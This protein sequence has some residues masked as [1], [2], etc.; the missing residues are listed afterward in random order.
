MG[1]SSRRGVAVVALV[2]ALSSCSSTA[3]ST[4]STVPPPAESVQLG[5]TDGP[6]A[7]FGAPASVGD[8]Q[9]TASNPVVGSDDTGPWLT[10]TV[11]AENQSPADTAA[12]QFQLRCSGSTAGGAWLPTSTF[13]QDQSVPAGAA[14]EGTLSLLLPGDEHLGVARPLCATPATVV[15]THLTFDNNGA[16]APVEKR[17]TWAVPDDLVAQLNTAPPRP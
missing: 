2:V 3:E 16:G 6:V 12:P 15:A 9:V 1:P 7:T 14:S 8:L 11:R 5:A 17:V 4:P 13:K 10:L